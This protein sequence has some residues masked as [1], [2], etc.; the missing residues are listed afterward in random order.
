MKWGITWLTIV[1]GGYV[2]TNEEIKE[3]L[4]KYFE[5]QGMKAEGGR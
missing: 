1:G 5:E 4:E 2:M 3:K